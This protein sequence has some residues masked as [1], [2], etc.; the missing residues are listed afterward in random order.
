MDKYKCCI[1]KTDLPKESFSLSKTSK[2]G[3]QSQCKSCSSISRKSKR[4]NNIEYYRNQERSRRLVKKQLYNTTSRE[5]KKKV[6]AR[7]SSLKLRAKKHGLT[8]IIS[9]EEYKKIISINICHYCGGELNPTGSGLDRIDPKLSYIPSN[10][11]PCCKECNTIK[12][13]IISYSEMKEVAKLLKR[14]RNTQNNHSN[15]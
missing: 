10:V 1:C 8:G 2:R 14:L 15:S 13:D 7:Y 4:N 6:G 5:H 12:S 3:L 9:F 11:V